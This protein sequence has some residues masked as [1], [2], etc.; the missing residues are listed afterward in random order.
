MNEAVIIISTLAICLSVIALI[1]SCV[2]I[3]MVC[4]FLR[5]THTIQWKTLDTA[6]VDM[7]D[8]TSPVNDPF[9]EYMGDESIPEE[10]PFKRKKKEAPKQETLLEQVMEEITEESNF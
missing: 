5:S 6:S 3:A 10:N 4:G 2:A 8:L 1:L 7:P 9:Q